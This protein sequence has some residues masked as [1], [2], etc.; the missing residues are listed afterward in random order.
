MSLICPCDQPSLVIRIAIR[1]RFFIQHSIS[2]YFV[3]QDFEVYFC[4][5]DWF[6]F[7]YFLGNPAQD[8]SP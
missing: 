6:F 2:F 5:A 8:L 3:A 7:Y 4:M 1:K